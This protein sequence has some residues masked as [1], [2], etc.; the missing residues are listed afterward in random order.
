MPPLG[1]DLPYKVNMSEI[2]ALTD[3][4]C[5]KLMTKRFTPLIRRPWTE[6]FE[7][8]RTL[9]Q[10]SKNVI[11]YTQRFDFWFEQ[12][13][14]KLQEY[15]RALFALCPLRWVPQRDRLMKR[16]EVG[17]LVVSKIGF[18]S[19]RLCKAVLKFY[20]LLLYI[21]HMSLPDEYWRLGESSEPLLQMRSV[22]LANPDL[23][24]LGDLIEPLMRMTNAYTVIQ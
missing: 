2:V 22:V 24:E 8:C 16:H 10:N 18:S 1:S 19:K 20:F 14:L 23:K 6:Y 12:V 21:P 9:E 11:K 5:H 4:E 13:D 7:H 3:P 15:V 17:T